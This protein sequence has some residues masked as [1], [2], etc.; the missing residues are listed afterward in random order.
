MNKQ[1]TIR[2]ITD[3]NSL[4]A[5]IFKIAELSGLTDLSKVSDYVLTGFEK[6]ALKKRRIVFIMILSELSGKVPKILEL[7]KSHTSALINN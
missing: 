4:S 5:I 2:A 6:A 7:L 1:E 3:L